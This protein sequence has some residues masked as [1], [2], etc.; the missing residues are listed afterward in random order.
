MKITFNISFL[1]YSIILILSGYINYLIIYLLIMFVHELGHIIVIKLLKYKINKII[2]LPFGGIIETNI[3]LNIKSTHL[4]LISIS[5]ILMQ[6]LLFLIIK[7]NYTYTYQIFYNLN[8]SLII[9]NLL[10]IIPNDG[11]KILLSI[12]ESIFKYRITNIISIIISF[13]FIYI[14]YIKTQNTVIFIVLFIINIKNILNYKYI[15][16][17]FLLERYL[18][19]H[20]YK[21]NKYIKN[22]KDIYKCSNNYIIYDKIIHEEEIVLE[23]LFMSTY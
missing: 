2:I 6:L 9:Y 20:K 16:N 7:N 4:F 22:I 1:I 12:N 15:Y 8:L 10:P 21:T 17:K 23:K 11:S 5:G 18:Y 13:I 14:F 19:K 3:N